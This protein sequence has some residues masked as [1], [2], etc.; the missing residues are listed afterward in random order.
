MERYDT[1]SVSTEPSAYHTRSKAYPTARPMPLLS[2][3]R[4]PALPISYLNANTT[5]PSFYLKRYH[6]DTIMT[7]LTVTTL[8]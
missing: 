6:I 2:H 4:K 7:E 1:L 8:D 5:N 3:H